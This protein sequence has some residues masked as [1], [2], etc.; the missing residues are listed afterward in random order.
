MKGIVT[1]DNKYIADV[2]IPSYQV[3]AAKRLKPAAF[4]D[5]TQEMAYLAAK[6]MHFGFTDLMAHNTV[7]VLSRM[8]ILFANSPRW[9]DSVQL[10]TWYKGLL[11][12]FCLRDFR[13]TN[14]QGQE[15]ITATSLWAV[16]DVETRAL[17]QVAEVE[18][19]VPQAALCTDCAIVTPAGKVVVP[20]SLEKEEVGVHTVTYSDVDMVGHTN[21]TRYVSWA[22]D[23]VD[24]DYL[25]THTIAEVSINFNHETRPGETVRLLRSRNAD[26]WYIEGLVDAT[27]VFA[28]RL[29]FV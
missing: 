23:C 13:M 1:A 24:Y 19:M 20:K 21:N 15:I 11:A 9:E 29:R 10:S 6:E 8:Q 26:T 27:Q 14:A 2:I 16:I 4:M 28:V 3:D 5:L 18:R 17:A 12:S 25:L 7:W 22:M